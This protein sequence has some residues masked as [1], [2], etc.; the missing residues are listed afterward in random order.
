MEA[1]LL[2]LAALATSAVPNLLV[3]GYSAFIFN[4]DDEQGALLKT[5]LGPLLMKYPLS[6]S[7]EVRHSAE[8][9]SLTALTPGA[10]ETLPFKLPEV[11]GVIGYK[12][13]RAVVTTLLTGARF[14]DLNDSDKQALAVELTEAISALHSL[15]TRLITSEGLPSAGSDE[16][17]N[18]ARKVINRVRDA[19]LLPVSIE[20]RWNLMLDDNSLWDFKPTVIHGNLEEEH[21][22]LDGSALSGILEW[23]SLQVGD[24][25]QDMAWLSSYPFWDQV[26]EAY[27]A[28]FGEADDDSFSLRAKFWHEF[29]LAKWLLHGI[30]SRDEDVVKD[31]IILFDQLVDNV[32]RV[33]L[34]KKQVAISEQSVEAILAQTPILDSTTSDTAAFE[35]LDDERAF[36]SD[37]D[38][39]WAT[40]Q[41]DR[42]LP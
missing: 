20:E 41:E 24:P 17:R 3:E 1:P 4:T 33:P 11:L 36:A 9:L 15:P 2:T 28:A 19:G 10:R 30:D 37:H 39:D 26:L 13:T 7:A 16:V 21:I 6:A 34:Q 14:S 5:N 29:S 38:V 12:D 31:A 22:L 32:S 27:G 42:P 23:S 25:A 8:I 35:A 40:E 18:S